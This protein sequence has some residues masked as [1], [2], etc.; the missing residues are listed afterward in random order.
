M[1]PADFN[2]PNEARFLSHQIV[3][4]QHRGM[5]AAM[6]EYPPA[7]QA[8]SRVTWNFQNVSQA[9]TVYAAAYNPNGMEW[10]EMLP[11]ES[12]CWIE[13]NYGFYQQGQSH[14]GQV[15]MRPMTALDTMARWVIPKYRGN[16]RNVQ[17][18]VANQVPDLPRWL[19]FNTEGAPAESVVVRIEY[20]ENG[21]LIE[22][23][24]YGVKIQRD[25]PPTYGAAGPL[26]QTNWGFARLFCF[27]AEKG[28]LDALRPAFWRI[29]QSVKIN[30]E[31]ERLC[32]QV[33]QQLA[34][35]FNQ[36]IQAGYDQINAA[37]RL[38]HMIS[39]QNDAWLQQQ[40]QNRDAAWAADQQRRHQEQ[41]RNDYTT[42]DAFGDYIMGRESYND[43]YYQ[44][45]SQHYG[46]YQ[47]VWTDSQGNYQYSNDANFNPN[48]GASAN[49]TLM[50]KKQIG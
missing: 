46:Y 4:Q 13:P 2:R 17:I 23:E 18:T 20:N 14:L 25:C 8:T 36:H 26:Y 30:P 42:N 7:W 43:P 11:V 41:A 37:T 24:F 45:G 16:R 31:W 15:Y 34:D 32:G 49:W 10:L 21:K 3:D 1:T 22:E 38:S 44:D 39:A 19:N 27:R 48:L 50:E 40:Q 9:L 29:M 28:T 35:L 5:I 47:Y 12:F 6:F 33:N